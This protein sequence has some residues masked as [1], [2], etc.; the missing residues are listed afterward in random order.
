MQKRILGRTGLTVSPIALGGSPFGY[1][2]KAAG[3]DPY[4]PEGRRAAIGTI[5]HA[6]DRGI[7][8][9]DTAPLYGNGHSETLIG[10][11]M[12]A[13][14]KECVLASKVW[15]EQDRQ[16]VIDSVHE[17][18]KRLQT[19]YLDIVQMHGRMYTNEEYARIVADGGPLDGLRALREAGKI[20][21]IGITTEEPWTVLPFLQHNKEVDLFQI[22]YNF[23]YQA[24]ARHFLIEAGKANAAVVT[25][26]T[27]TSGVLQLAAS[28]LA[29]NWQ[30]AHDLYEV[31][32]KFVLSDS[33][34]HA[35]LIGMRT[36]DEVDRNVAIVENFVPSFDFANLPRLTGE[37]Y[38]AE[39]ADQAV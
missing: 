6:L 16:T 27:M 35:G 31:S 23:I 24:A 33:R 3:W 39:D 9:I 30:K 21:F 22:A 4:S 36:K 26:R 37:V 19:D 18:L 2:H 38:K 1:A 8:Y 15:Y 34:V 5:H 28:Y 32:L 13:R 11:V 10:E 20:G 25:M 12:K 29:P 14:R 7:T 17:S